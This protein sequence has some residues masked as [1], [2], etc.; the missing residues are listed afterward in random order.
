[1]ST[2]KNTSVTIV[3]VS[4]LLNNFLFIAMVTFLLA[5]AIT[6]LVIPSIIR[7][8]EIKNLYDEPDNERKKHVRKTPTLGGVA[9]F[10]GLIISFSLVKDFQ[11]L[12]DVRYMIPA[13][14]IIFIAG[15]KDDVIELTPMK[16]LLAQFISAIMIAGLSN[17]KINSFYG[18]LGL[19][20]MP[21]W[22]AVIFTIMVII[23]IINCYNLVDGVD[24]LAGS[25]GLLAAISFGVWFY[26]TGHWSLTFLSISLAGSLFGFL[27]F[28]WQP[29]KIF[30]GD[31]GAM[32]IG[33][34]LSVLAIHFIELNKSLSISAE[35]WVHAS[36][37]VAMG[38][39]ALPIFDMIR[40]FCLRVFRRKSPF[41][42]DRTHLHHIFL[43]L[44]FSHRS[45][46]SIIVVWNIVVVLL[47]FAFRDIK[48]SHMLVMLISIVF[49]P[50]VILAYIRDRKMVN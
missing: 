6:V 19:Q 39:M 7:V 50:S 5:F 32:L 25:L 36:P 46:V 29:A 16:K 27:L 10:A 13:L 26:L 1:M 15:V 4:L 42:P 21:S 3:W 47:C 35:Y 33:F 2:F 24:G 31:T 14:I 18:M 34:I 20:E 48:S 38:I 45:L 12:Y 49:V 28:N 8:A 44:G 41:K 40:V 37:G 30:M 9:I 22:L 17:I 23:T 11:N 43:D